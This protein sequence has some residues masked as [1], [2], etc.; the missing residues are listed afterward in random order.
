M[1]THTAQQLVARNVRRVREMR[2]MSLARLATALGWK[3]RN[4]AHQLENGHRSITVDELLALAM[5][6]HV[7]PAVLLVPWEND[8]QLAVA[9]TGGAWT[10][11]LDSAEAY[12]WI[13]GAPEPH[14]IALVANITD[15]FSTTP[16]AVQRRYGTELL[17]RLR[18]EAGWKISDDGTVV[19]TGGIKV[20]RGKEQER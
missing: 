1:E 10:T 14:L 9:L 7:A 8:E 13:I 4:T 12:G 15:Y 2:G 18:E 11:H 17:R 19:D 16:S 3:S 20:S 5:A 6:L